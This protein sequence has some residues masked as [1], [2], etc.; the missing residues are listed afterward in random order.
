VVATAVD[1]GCNGGFFTVNLARA[2]VATV[3]VEREPKFRRTAATSLRRAGLANAGILD[4]DVTPETVRLL[5]D[6]DL[7]LFLSVWHHMVRAYGID[8]A[9]DLLAAIWAHTAT[10]MMFDSAARPRCRRRGACLRS[11]TTPQPGTP[12]T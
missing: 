4:L 8:I 9:D 10:V 2:G 7:V 5:P 6:A 12:G 11:A 1:I 3:G